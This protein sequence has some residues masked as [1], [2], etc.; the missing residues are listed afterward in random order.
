MRLLTGHRFLPLYLIV[1]N[2]DCLRQRKLRNH[3]CRSIKH[4]IVLLHGSN[5]VFKSIKLVNLS[6]ELHHAIHFLM[7][8]TYLSCSNFGILVYTVYIDTNNI[9]W[10]ECLAFPGKVFS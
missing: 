10:D 9:M 4:V 2:I 7:G 8:H 1:T 5:F 3:Y 6:M